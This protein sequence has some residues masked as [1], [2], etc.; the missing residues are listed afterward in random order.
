[1]VRGKAVVSGQ[2]PV[3]SDQLGSRGSSGQGKSSGQWSV[4][5]GKLLSVVSGHCFPSD[6]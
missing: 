1:M 2:W 4:V 5:R 6:H 3:V